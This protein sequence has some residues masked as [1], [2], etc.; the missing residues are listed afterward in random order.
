VG[1]RGE[2]ERRGGA[3][4]REGERN[5]E[6]GERGRGKRKGRAWPGAGLARFITRRKFCDLAPALLQARLYSLGTGSASHHLSVCISIFS[7]VCG[8]LLFFS[9]ARL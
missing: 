9:R 8:M 1:E 7:Y 3:A 6:I 5:R 4:R 2:R